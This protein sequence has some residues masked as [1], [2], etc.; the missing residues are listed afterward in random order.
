MTN[1]SIWGG[2]VGSIVFNQ[3]TISYRGATSASG[4]C[5]ESRQ[6]HLMILELRQARD[7]DRTNR[8]R[9]DVLSILSVAS[10]PFLAL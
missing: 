3:L 5:D 1:A 9:L 7:H 10:S 8:T 6:T 4:D 2:Q